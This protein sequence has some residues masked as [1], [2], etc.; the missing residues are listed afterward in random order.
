MKIFIGCDHAA[1]KE[2]ESLKQALIEDNHEL[3]DCGCFSE[4]RCNYP[5]FAK[6]VSREVLLNEGSRGVLICGSGIGISMVANRHEKIRAA[7]CRTEEDA[8]LSREHND[9]NILCLG[10]RLTSF[11]KLILIANTWLQTSFEGNRHSQRIALFNDIGEKFKRQTNF[12]DPVEKVI[13]I[14]MLA[15]IILGAV[16]GRVNV[17]YFEGVY[18]REDGFLEWLSVVALLLGASFSIR[19]LISLWNQRTV[20]F[21]IILFGLAGLFIFGAGEE[22]SWGQ[23]LFSFKSSNY[24]LTANTQGEFNLHNLVIG[25]VKLNKLIFGKILGLC[26]GIYFLILP[27][28]YRK[29]S[30]F[31][32]WCNQSGIPIPKLLHTGVYILI[33]LLAELNGTP[34]KG[35]ILEFGG[36][37][38]FF[39]MIMWPYNRDIYDKSIHSG[40]LAN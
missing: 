34:K 9:A 25:G 32:I 4:D 40:E 37:W 27:F 22:I 8:R 19:R 39:L 30:R 10:A 1:Y 28:I 26:I 12:F 33:I 38:I 2:K 15:I 35:E 23:R 11:D 7:L 20:L 16:L 6:K 31:K 21:K 24:F 5:D 18:A 3:I 17:S 29:F 36:C 13:V 14:C